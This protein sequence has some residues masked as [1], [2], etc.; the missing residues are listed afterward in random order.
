MIEVFLKTGHVPKLAYTNV[1]QDEID[2]M[3]ALLDYLR[4]F[5]RVKIKAS[6]TATKGGDNA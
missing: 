2:A 1:T 3:L 5:L 4:D 6:V